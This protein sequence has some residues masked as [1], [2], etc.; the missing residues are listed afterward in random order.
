MAGNDI[1]HN[2]SS[3]KEK[4]TKKTAG[5][6][7]IHG[8][9]ILTLGMGLVKI[10]GAFFKVPLQEIIGEYGMGL[11]SV[12]YNFYGPIHSLAAAGLPIAISRLVAESF[13]L[14]RFRDI[15][16]IKKTATPI[17]IGLGTAGT[18]VMLVGAPLYCN[19]VIGNANA[20]LPMLMLAPAVLFGCL[21]SIYRGFNEGLKN[22]YPTAISE[23]IEALS[24][25]VIGLSAAFFVTQYLERE[26]RTA[27]TVLGSVMNSADDAA[28][29]TLSYAAAAAIFGVTCGSILSFLFLFL[30]HKI[31][32]DGIT[33]EMLQCSPRPYKRKTIAR[34]LVR[35]AIPVAIGSVTMSVSGL[36]D[37]TFLQ[38]RI[39]DM[40]A[41]SADTLLKVYEGMIPET[42]L[43]QPEA[44]P[45]FLFGCY[46]LAM[47]VYMLV[48]TLTQAFSISALPN[49][50]ALWASG[51]KKAL[52]SGIESV[53]RVSALFSFPAGFG[54]CAVSESITALL[55]GGDVSAPIISSVM[56]VL[57]IAAAFS[58]V[59][60]PLSSML[61]A[62]GRA[63]LP[64]KLLLVGMGMK[65]AINYFLCGIPE[66]NIMGAGIG[67]LCCYMF[68]MIAEVIALCRV[69]GLR[70]RILSV[71]GKP[72]LSAL[73][74]AVTAFV[75][76]RLAPDSLFGDGRG[77][78]LL[79][80]GLAIAAGAIVYLVF[81][82]ILRGIDK[83]DVNMLPKGE[84]I[85]KILEKYNWI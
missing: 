5:Q 20:I 72:F 31:R 56:S 66:I 24:K 64:V 14:G 35:T 47:T 4:K 43:R 8:A 12:A 29:T 69:V 26:Y 41:V 62:V 27:G 65:I 73:L 7:F 1:L 84:K 6:S 17:F 18:L 45:N 22:M 61:Q 78:A 81:L 38:S 25:L 15:R 58:A 30:R 23:I 63:D 85:A 28:L 76:A 34:R 33:N 70:V 57:G 32:G 21:G 55:Y 67:T 71:F 40:M 50:T 59:T 44:V 42:Y 16:N 3:V 37:T 53:I 52:K 82:V 75:T 68:L 51:D 48:P 10:I 49:I 77:N 80:T 79:S 74:C 2:R 60:T 46:T 9:L 19:Q 54:I 39:A 83:N 11:F 36:I 13:S